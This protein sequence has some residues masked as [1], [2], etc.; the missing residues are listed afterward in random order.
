MG[1]TW[2]FDPRTGRRVW[3]FPDG[4]YST[5]V[6]AGLNR[7]VIAAPRYLYLLRTKG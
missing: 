1:N 6:T 5:V 4:W 2:A 3:H 7:L